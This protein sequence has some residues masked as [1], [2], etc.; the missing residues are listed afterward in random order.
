MYNRLDE[1]LGGGGKIAAD[2]LQSGKD[3]QEI[4]NL[5]IDSINSNGLFATTEHIA[6]VRDCIGQ[7]DKQSEQV[8]FQT[9]A[10]QF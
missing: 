8:I 3:R 2:P 5:V 6:S 7:I 1:I 4:R 10:E 9:I